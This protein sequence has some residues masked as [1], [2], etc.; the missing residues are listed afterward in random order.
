MHVAFSYTAGVMSAINVTQHSPGTLADM[1]C[2]AGDVVVK[3]SSRCD[4]A[5]YWLNV[6]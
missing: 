6:G 1:T 4:K 2:S 5:A 3:W